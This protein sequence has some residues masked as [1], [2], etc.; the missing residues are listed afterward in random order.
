M[1]IEK[2]ETLREREKFIT[3][4][5]W[6]HEEL[7]KTKNKFNDYDKKI[8]TLKKSS[9]GTYS[10]DLILAQQI[11]D[12]INKN[13][14]KYEEAKEQPYFA[15]IDFR[16]KR[17]EK[18]SF[19]IG[20]FGLN[21]EENNEEVVI[22]WRAPIANLYY[23]G[24][25][26]QSYYTSPMGIIEGDLSLKRKFLVKDGD[27]EEI[28]DEGINELIVKTSAEGNELIDEF[29]KLNLEQSMSKKL[30]DV[31][32]TIQKEQNEIIRA[33]K[34]K[35]II[36][37]G[38]AG[39]GKTTVALHRLAYLIYTYGN[40]E[41]NENI[42]VVAPNKLFIDYISDVLPNLGV[43]SVKQNT[44][45]ELCIEILKIKGK[46]ITKDEKLA[47]IMEEEQINS[48]KY[49]TSSSKVKGSLAFKSILDRYIKF[50]ESKDSDVEDIEVEGYTLFTSKEIKKL[51]IRDLAHLPVKKRKEE[52][53][54]YFKQKVKDKIFTVEELIDRDYGFRVKDIK[55]AINI[56]EEEKRQQIISVYNERDEKKKSLKVNSN[57][58]LKEFFSNWE[59]LDLNKCYIDLF[60]NGATFKEIT[61]DTIPQKLYEY[62]R[63]ELNTNSQKKLIDSDDL[64]PL[65]YLKL[66]F[67]GTNLDKFMHLV[68]DEAQD[69]SYFQMH[70]LNEIS[71]NSSMTI[72]G[73]L[74]QGIYNYKG[75][76][77]WNKL[78]ESVFKQD[79]TYIALSQSYR[80]TVEIIS[81]ANRVLDK[82]N[83][84]LIPAMP[85][86]RHGE[87]PR[88]IKVP[89]N[90]E[91]AKLID[92]IVTEI[93]DKKKHSV[94][95]ICKTFGQCK[96]LY[97]ELDNKSSYSWVLIGE[98]E[99]NISMERIIIP[100]YMTKGLEF[101]AT[102]IY[103][104]D[105]E[106]YKDN[107]LDKR[108]LYVAL[109]RALHLEYII[110]SGNLT[111]LL[112]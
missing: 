82:Q 108:L 66:K 70:L 38:S 3:T 88:T 104:C 97:K 34:N 61:K 63:E 29:L 62:M 11:F 28:F 60:N 87:M 72:V 52:I 54:K 9:G 37:Q 48:V 64:T 22:D 79:A 42:L 96:E 56:S 49:I 80:S 1:V 35:P 92:D 14:H 10:D 8:S 46:I 18:E 33:Y 32:A 31:V 25:F 93:Y 100:S 78:I 102:I 50:L 89:S 21:D 7:D 16:E 98:N 73:D 41:K 81:V 53:K 68:V 69:Y 67:E 4:K 36:I 75:I 110:F 74:G 112:E 58:A 101:D 27:L 47:K 24:T 23:S 83:L 85:V 15:R 6:I 39:S 5:N 2:A 107:D 43:Y 44:Y 30:K 55:L 91:E 17:R 90:D 51:Y 111:K 45:E 94:A 76:A 26:G 106:N 57:K 103:N 77:S 59:S 95:I 65:T 86:L 84:N 105:D 20:K 19:Y 71:Q 13:L 12:F 109:T 99:N 40:E